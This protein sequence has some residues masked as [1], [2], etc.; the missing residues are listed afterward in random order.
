MSDG[1]P[2]QKERLTKA[3]DAAL[4]DQIGVLFKTLITGL[5]DATSPGSHDTADAA[6]GRFS[7][8][9]KLSWAAFERAGVV[10][11]SMSQP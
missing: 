10:V 1:T 6:V 5:I 9:M 4:D 8:G 2:T 3:L 7:R 11:D